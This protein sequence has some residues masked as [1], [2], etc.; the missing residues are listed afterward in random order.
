[1]KRLI[2]IIMLLVS[3]PLC[4]FSSIRTASDS[5]TIRAYKMATPEDGKEHIEMKIYDAV[6][7]SLK[8]IG[9]GES[10][11]LNKFLSGSLENNAL[12]GSATSGST[13]RLV[14][15]FNIEGNTMG[16]YS[17]TIEMKPFVLMNGEEEISDNKIRY[18]FHVMNDYSFF[19]GTES[20]ISIDGAKVKYIKNT[21]GAQTDSTGGK[22]KVSFFISG[23]SRPSEDVW[24]V[25]GG[26]GIVMDKNDY[27]SAPNGKYRAI[28][29]VTLTENT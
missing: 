13:G 24:T 25:R 27:D 20:D 4:L 3:V 7:D 5:L 17:V 23:L 14:Y 12:I 10:I 16:D 19:K 18:Y 22:I 29:K 6:V 2:I 1:M 21:I 15:A 26:I 11:N 9:D 28:A 8:T